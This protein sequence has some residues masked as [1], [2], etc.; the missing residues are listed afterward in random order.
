MVSTNGKKV[1]NTPANM[2]IDPIVHEVLH[3]SADNLK[4]LNNNPIGIN[5]C[6]IIIIIGAG[7]TPAV[8]HIVIE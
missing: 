4:N 6:G 3:L 7:N 1:I 8:N 2:S 5:I